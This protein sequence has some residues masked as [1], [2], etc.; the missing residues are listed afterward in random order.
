MPPESRADLRADINA[1]ISAVGE[2][3]GEIVML[4]GWLYALTG[5][6]AT[7]LSGVIASLMTGAL[8]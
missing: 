5:A 4:K 3:K 7:I 8:H 6:C 1:L 2:L